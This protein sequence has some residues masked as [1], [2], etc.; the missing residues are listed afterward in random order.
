METF[1]RLKGWKPEFGDP[2]TTITNYL[3]SD[4][5][6]LVRF[7]PAIKINFT[8]KM[9]FLFEIVLLC[10]YVQEVVNYFAHRR[11]IVWR[12]LCCCERSERLKIYK[13]FE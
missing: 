9:R 6:L 2:L 8:H 1:E 13:A 3:G 7:Q 4:G 11:N 12:K 10:H 5:T